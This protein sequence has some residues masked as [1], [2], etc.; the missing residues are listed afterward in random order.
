LVHQI[1]VGLIVALAHLLPAAQPPD[2]RLAM[3]PT[4]REALSR[5]GFRDGEAAPETPELDRKLTSSAFGRSEQAFVAA[6]YFEDE[7]KDG[8]LGPLRVSRFDRQARGWT[9]AAAFDEN[10]SGSV[11]SVHSTPRYVLVSLH[12]T[13]SAGGVLVLGSSRLN[14]LVTLG[15]FAPLVMADGSIIFSGNMT[16]FA[17]THQQRLLAFDPDASREIELFP[18]KKESPLAAGY[19]R[20]VRRAYASLSQAVKEEFQD[21]SDGPV[22]DYDRSIGSVHEGGDGTRIAFH[23]TYNCFRIENVVPVPPMRTL[24]RCD[25]RA[26]RPWSCGERELEQ[27][28]RDLHYQLARD[29]EGHLTRA[30]LDSLVDTV[31]RRP[32]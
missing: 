6:Y 13:P 28:A 8:S 32:E 4:L 3:S 31:L 9:H 30:T 17:P 25:R 24:V 29:V 23:V 27:V 19:R 10:M 18:G 26:K 11:T 20:V 15:G 14:L 22:D 12:L 5:S 7:L 1:I 2:V 16:H 21:S